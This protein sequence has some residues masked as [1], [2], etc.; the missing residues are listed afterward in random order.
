M[1]KREL[2]KGKGGKLVN[3]VVAAKYKE[4]E[5]VFYLHEEFDSEAANIYFEIGNDQVTQLIVVPFEL[6]LDIPEELFDHNFGYMF[7]DFGFYKIINKLREQI[8]EV[9]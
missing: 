1:E 5:W 9:D 3:Y 8:K 4:K 2:E 7:H 6:D